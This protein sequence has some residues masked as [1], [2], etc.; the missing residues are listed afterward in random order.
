MELDI[1]ALSRFQFALTALYHFLFVPLTLGLSVLLAIMETVYVMTGRQIWRQMTKFWGTL[2]G[3]NFV[4]G[5][6][7]GIV[8]EFQFGMNWSYYSYYVGDI[9]GAP[10]AIEGLM[11]FFLEATFVGLF[12]FGWDKLSKVGHLVATWAVALGSNFSALW[13]LIAN[14][15]MQNPVGSALNPQTMRMEITS[16][17]DVVF[18][19]VAQA[20]FV[21][22]VSAGYV[23]ASIFV[24]GVSAWY[25][26]KG[27][28]IEL[29]KRSMT[30]AASFGLAS[31]LSVVVLGDESGYL[32]TENQKM[33]LAAIEG[34]WK[35]EPAP[36]AF[37]AFGFPDQE[38]RETHFAVHIPWVMG[39]IGTRS[40]T[41]EIPG[42]D[43]L[44]QQAE[45]RIRDGIKAYDALMQIRTAPAQDQVA[46][47]VRSSFEDLG[48]DLG[49]ALLLKRYVD[50]PRQATD[51]QIAQAARDTIPHV[52]TL[53]W[54][55]RIMVGLGMFFILLTATF[56]WLSARRHLDTYPLLLRIAVL[57]IPLPW[58]AIE[59]GWVVAE[60]GR[61]PWVIEGVLPTAAAVSSLGA[62]TVL[63]TI[64]GFGALYSVLIVIEMSL[65]IKAIRQGPEPDDEPES[66][67]ISETLIPAAE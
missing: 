57:A 42:I 62:S 48:H 67:L 45:T 23:C 11:A 18:N 64:I 56:F 15:W 53:F 54:S 41:T 35:T 51:A 2:F 28:H 19:P 20:K 39:L 34:M 31:A 32:A 17:F 46:Q 9:F 40:L 14:G 60:F 7:T 13:I 59:L 29:A 50:D 61:Q 47:E 37:T 33:K 27:R 8:M 16:F 24:L 52:P 43:K 30:V 38:A 44:E 5:V 55:F 21:H 49:Y 25:V 12:F 4:I 26:L 65:M 10:L 36:A 22:T 6:A 1:V 58:V 3:I 66:A 63:L